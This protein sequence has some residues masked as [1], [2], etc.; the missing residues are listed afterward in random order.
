MRACGYCIE[1]QIQQ[2]SSGTIPNVIAVTGHRFR[3][4][5]SAKLTEFST[6]ELKVLGWEIRILFPHPLQQLV[7]EGGVELA[8]MRHGIDAADTADVRWQGILVGPAKALHHDRDDVRAVVQRRG[9]LPPGN[10][11][12]VAATARKEI[13]RQ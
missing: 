10:V 8:G 1:L 3:N 13:R 4:P 5:D 6:T 7:N 2:R 9:N 11:L 12:L